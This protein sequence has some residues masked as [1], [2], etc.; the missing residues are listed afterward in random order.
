VFFEFFDGDAYV[1]DYMA[2]SAASKIWQRVKPPPSQQLH[3]TIKKHN[4]Y[5]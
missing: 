4:H 2:S 3:S 1:V 5:P